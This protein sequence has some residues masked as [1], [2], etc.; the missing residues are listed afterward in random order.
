M[1]KLQKGGCVEEQVDLTLLNTVLV[2][3]VLD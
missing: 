3:F 1:L 2:L